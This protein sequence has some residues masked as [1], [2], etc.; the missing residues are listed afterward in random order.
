MYSFLYLYLNYDGVHVFR[1]FKLA[2]LLKSLSQ[3]QLQ[4]CS[5]NIVGNN[6]MSQE[7]ASLLSLKYCLSDLS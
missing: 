3:L 5:N 4:N 1:C 6:L 2:F 7:I